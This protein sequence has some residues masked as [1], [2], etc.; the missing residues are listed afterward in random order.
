MNSSVIDTATKLN[1]QGSELVDLKCQFERMSQKVPQQRAPEPPPVSTMPTKMPG[2]PV[3]ERRAPRRRE[4]LEAT[5]SEYV[6]MID[7]KN[8]S[9]P[10]RLMP[11]L[12]QHSI[13]TGFTYP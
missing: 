7:L 11:S 3:P 10:A 2:T 6:A 12:L 4:G 9:K 1:I 8:P 5:P 13:N